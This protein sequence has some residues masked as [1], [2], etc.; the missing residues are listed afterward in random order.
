MIRKLTVDSAQLSAEAHWDS[1]AADLVIRA[2]AISPQTP[3]NKV[4]RLLEQNP[5]WPALAIIDN[6]NRIVGLVARGQCLSILSKPLMLDLYSKRPVE[7]IMH[8]AH[9]EV[10]VRESIDSVLQCIANDNSDALISGFVVTEN[11]AYVGVATAQELLVKSVEQAR[12][13]SAA[14]DK[15]RR[16]AEQASLAKSTFL[17]NLSHEIR[18]PLNGVLANLE[19]LGLTN[20]DPEQVDLIGSAAVAA[21]ALFE[22]IGDVLDL[23]KIE[24]GKLAVETI[25]TP[26]APL[27][28][29]LST[30][31]GTQAGM[32]D[33]SFTAHLSPSALATIWGDPT[34]LRQILMNLCGN[35]LKFT[36][37]GGLFLSLFS[38]EGS[39]GGIEL[40]IEIADTG[41][42][43]ASHKAE[44]LFEA[45][46]QEDD[47]TTRKFGGTGLG[48]SICR[49]LVELM[50]GTIQAD[51]EPDGGATFW[52]RIPLSVVV[53]ADGTLADIAGLSV[54]IIDH[55]RDRGERLV[56]GLM[57]G[58]A[59]AT[60]LSNQDAAFKRL[61]QAAADGQ[62][63][64]VVLLTLKDD[65]ADLAATMARL[66]GLSTVP[67]SITNLEDVRLRRH[68]FRH[69][70][71]YWT[72]LSADQ[73]DIHAT[74][75][76]AAG[77]MTKTSSKMPTLDISTLT[78]S[79]APMRAA[80]I[81][82]IDD[83]PMNRQVAR[84][85]LA[86]LGFGCDT[87][88][89]G[90]AGLEQATAQSY[91]LILSDIQMPRMDGY[92]FVRG[93]RDWEAHH[94][95]GHVPVIAM[96]ANA[97]N[98]DDLK[99]IEAGMD[100]YVVKPVKIE[101]LASALTRW[102]AGDTPSG[103]AGTLIALPERQ[104]SQAAAAID[105]ECL[106]EQLGDDSPDSHREVLEMFLE[107]YPPLEQALAGAVAATDRPGTRTCA[108]TAKGAALNTAAVGLGNILYRI[109]AT[110]FEA[111]WQDIA[112]LLDEARS[113]FGRV[114]AFSVELGR[115]RSVET[116][117]AR[118]V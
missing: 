50:G 49:R 77:R 117:Q 29:D 19:L 26:L 97:M 108:H 102:L 78:A 43:F 106:S 52:C 112:T 30:M 111:N 40:W 109:E 31:V 73:S 27:F 79:L 72:I 70:I 7:R 59:S 35:S 83:T 28:H 86:K 15:A 11:G 93:F 67:V 64:D 56:G 71:R 62:P 10:D 1:V 113:E 21:Q 74:I 34:R 3:C 8:T 38:R 105:L 6:T 58:G 75:A 82:V 37:A 33:L 41:G 84:R 57:S 48:L 91:D 85:Q 16:L 9:L 60:T 69:G 95:G 115:V 18:T 32:R 68:G 13:R 36:K 96:T 24:A 42:G 110:A 66:A 53:A 51:G 25:P 20:A 23:S 4:F 2:P 92:S 76:A 17:A 98:G 99:C 54:M 107:S 47:S 63:F 22:I 116:R 88:D 12:R 61:Q 103:S 5:Q 89:D 14:L 104:P 100:D 118:R 46:A 94:G 87:A 90:Q 65:E 45:F 44:H 55:V 114:R 80:R 81:L 101:R 39:G